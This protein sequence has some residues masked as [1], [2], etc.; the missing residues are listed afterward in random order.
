MKPRALLFASAVLAGLITMP[1]VAQARGGRTGMIALQVQVEDL[2]SHQ[3]IRYGV[4]PNAETIPL[5]VGQ[6]VRVS[7][8]GTAIVNNV[9]VERPVRSRFYVAAGGGSLELGSGGPNSVVV[10]GRGISGNG[11]AQLGYDVTDNSYEMKPGFESG[12]ITFQM[13]GGAP[14]PPPPGGGSRR[15]VADQVTRELYRAILRQDDGGRRARE[16]AAA[17][18]RGGL[19]TIQRVATSLAVAAEANGTADR[20]RAEEVVG[21]LYRELL[22][23]DMGNRE[24]AYQDPGFRDNVRV[25]RDRGLAAVVDVIVGSQ[26]YQKVHE[27]ERYG[28][29]GGYRR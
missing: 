27:L 20:R 26:E 29:L 5:A 17:I 1:V 18:E 14:P 4:R 22:H 8:V 24:I 15:D 10:R 23:R 13:S 11:L 28:M 7:L 3:Q 16:D 2:G 12:R 6:S 21:R 19:P 9:G 25:F